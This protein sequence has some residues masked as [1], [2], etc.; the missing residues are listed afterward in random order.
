MASK[1]NRASDEE[2]PHAIDEVDVQ[3]LRL[4]Q[5]RV[6]LVRR[7]CARSSAEIV[8]DRAEASR[9]IATLVDHAAAS[10]P[11]RRSANQASLSE[12]MLPPFCVTS[13]RLV[14]RP[15]QLMRVAFLGPEYSYSHL[16]AIK[17]FGDATHL[18]PVA[19]IPAVFDSVTR[20]DSTSGLVPIEN[21]TDGRIVDTLGMFVRTEMKIC[22]EVVLPIHHSL[23]SRTARAEVTEIH[24]KPQAL[25]QCR[26]W[27]AVNMPKRP[28]GRSQQHHR[29]RQVMRRSSTAWQQSQVWKR[30]EIRSGRVELEY[31]RQPQQCHSIRCL[32]TGESK[33]HG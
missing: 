24:S 26:E 1:K 2:T 6:G 25:S 13:R 19:S 29:G 16:A 5:Q 3:I 7:L 20:G 15:I 21:S 31:R 23:L 8:G 4:I 30:A 10:D 27:L 33:P 17:Y 28:V 18:I 14:C 11:S 32:G 22:G 12:L 9:R